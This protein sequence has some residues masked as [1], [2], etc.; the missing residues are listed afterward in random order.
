MV[1]VVFVVSDAPKAT[2]AVLLVDERAKTLSDP[3]SKDAVR[4]TDG[5]A[6]IAMPPRGVRM[7][8]VR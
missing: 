3:L 1:R 6:T 7:F 4:I 8:V 5:R 2:S